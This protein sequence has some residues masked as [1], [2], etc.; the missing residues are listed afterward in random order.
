MKTASCI[1]KDVEKYIK[2]HGL[3]IRAKELAKWLGIG[4]DRFSKEFRRAFKVCFRDWII[5]RRIEE[6]K[7]LLKKEV[8]VK[9]FLDDLGYKQISYFSKL[10]K[11]KAGESI[12]ECKKEARHEKKI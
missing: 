3:K 9:C 2:K 10:F 1:K 7:R 11:E 4:E 12:R 6:A 5:E 8:P